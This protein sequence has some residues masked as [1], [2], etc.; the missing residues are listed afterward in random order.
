MPIKY[1]VISQATKGI[2]SS[3]VRLQ[4]EKAEAAVRA[5]GYEPIDTIYEEDFDDGV[6]GDDVINPALWH[7]G[8]A[9][10]RL[11]KAHAIYMCDGWGAARGCRMERQ[12]AVAFGVDVMYE[13]D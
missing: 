5:A 11:S 6:S 8:L 2:D 3:K 4:R 1:A 12:A 10:A 13:V 9:L 7:M